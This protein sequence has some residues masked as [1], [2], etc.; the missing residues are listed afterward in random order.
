MRRTDTIALLL[1]DMTNPFFTTVAHGVETAAN[2]A[3]LA[4]LLANSTES[5][6]EEQRLIETLL[7]RRVDGICFVPAGDGTATIRQALENNTPVVA[8]DRRPK[9]RVAD[10]VRSD[11][12]GGAR[13]LG[14]LVT[15]LGHRVTAIVSGPVG[16]STADDRVRGFRH[17]IAACPGARPP[18]VFRGQFT[19]ESGRE[20]AR[21]AMAVHP[22]P[23]ALFAAN[24]FI[25]IGVL[26]V[27]A[28]L[29][30]RVPED[31]AVVGFDDLPPA[32]VIFPF[33][34]VAAQP[35]F[36]MG[37][38]SVGAAGGPLGG[39]NPEGTGD[40]APDGALDPPLERPADHSSGAHLHD[41][42]PPRGQGRRSPHLVL[43]A[44]ACLGALPQ[45]A[46]GRCLRSRPACAH[47]LLSSATARRPARCALSAHPAATALR[48]R[49]AAQSV[50]GQ[51]PV[52]DNSRRYQAPCRLAGRDHD[53]GWWSRVDCAHPVLIPESL[54]PRS[55]R[56]A[57][58]R[59]ADRPWSIRGVEEG[60]PAVDSHA[61]VETPLIGHAHP[62][63]IRANPRQLAETATRGRTDHAIQDRL[64]D[65]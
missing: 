8:L 27:L 30:I 35:A 28:E 48:L 60:R 54:R 10:I 7:Q 39:A 40:R 46:S 21:A 56:Q 52:I 38:R 11:S 44:S 4:L 13:Q 55:V 53:D 18:R 61:D 19:V 26:H 57:D 14:E 29:G 23:T 49:V 42:L 12:L 16:V 50:N 3:G 9:G 5:E 59:H 51:L 15:S 37:Q 31:V 22:R 25:A 41:R 65:A 47:A 63:A 58:G 2:A 43:A 20:M 33:L 32:I 24:N 1:S 36:E 34:T 17:A 6:A 64:V 62:L 45:P